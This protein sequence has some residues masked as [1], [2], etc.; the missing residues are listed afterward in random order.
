[1]FLEDCQVIENREI[2]PKYYLLRVKCEKSKEAAKA[3]QFF[4]LKLK[5]GITLLRRPISLH[6]IDREAG[7]LEFYYESKGSGTNELSHLKVG[8]TINLQGPLGRG[9][10]TNLSDKTLV[11]I[12]GGMG[13]APMKLLIDELK[14]DNRVIFIAG[15]RG[16]F[17]LKILD[18][19]NLDGV[20]THICT[21]DGSQGK[22]GNVVEILKEVIKDNGSIHMVMSCGPHRMMEVVA[23]TAQKSDIHC[24]ISL[25]ERMACG[26]KACVGCS[27]KTLTGMKKVCH[28][29]PVFDSK[30]IV[31]TNPAENDPC[32]CN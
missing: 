16:A 18:N 15:G 4:M 25:E 7:V 23:E 31:E 29:G 22:H 19:F 1:M 5:N 26:V 10:T 11:L 24:E 9:F 3:G 32:N 17:A 2:H 27:I 13:L 6:Y 21:D 20:E 28:D 8:E 12:G 14:K 30:T